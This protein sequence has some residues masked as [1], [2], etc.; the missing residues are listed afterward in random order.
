[1]H[2][3]G[4]VNSG[5][6]CEVSDRAYGLSDPSLDGIVDVLR[7]IAET[8]GP[9]VASLLTDGGAP[10]VPKPTKTKPGAELI[11]AHKSPNPYAPQAGQYW[12]PPV[13]L[14]ATPISNFADVF[15]RLRDELL[16]TGGRIVAGTP[17]GRAAIQ[18]KVT[19]DIGRYFLPIAIGAGALVLVLAMTRR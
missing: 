5:W 15:A 11:P 3:D 18:E 10:R 6:G 17:A 1:M 4:G 9:T 12:V 8:A 7:G 14:Q 19:G 2:A 13:S 16:A